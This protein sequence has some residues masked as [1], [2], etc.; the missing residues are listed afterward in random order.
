MLFFNCFVSTFV[1]LI[2]NALLPKLC[3]SKSLVFLI[4]FSTP[5]SLY[6]S[7]ILCIFPCLFS[8]LILYVL[9]SSEENSH[10]EMLVSS[11]PREFLSST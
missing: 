5:L 9:A 8:L 1:Y 6:N 7:F 3:L 10:S 11:M 4:L 2:R